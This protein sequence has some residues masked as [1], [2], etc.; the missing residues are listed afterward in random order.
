MR[1]AQGVKQCVEQNLRHS[2]PAQPDEHKDNVSFRG[3]FPLPF[4]SFLKESLI[5]S[6]QYVLR[7]FRSV[8]SIEV[9]IPCA[10]TKQ[11]N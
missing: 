5:I 7:A 2:K 3:C 1:G 9:N 10:A 8:T 6:V 11:A 4:D